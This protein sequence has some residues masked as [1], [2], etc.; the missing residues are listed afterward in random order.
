MRAQTVTGSETL[1]TATKPNSYNWLCQVSTYLCPLNT[2]CFLTEISLWLNELSIKIILKGRTHQFVHYYMPYLADVTYLVGTQ[3]QRNKVLHSPT[4][5]K[6][7]CCF[8]QLKFILDN[9][10]VGLIFFFNLIRTY[11]GWE[12]D[13]KGG[14]NKQM[15]K[16]IYV[17]KEY[18]GSGP[19]EDSAQQLQC[20]W[21]SVQCI[22]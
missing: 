2:G 14:Q 7:P 16:L 17:L 10:H 22:L 3:T 4:H 9:I 19:R 5:W 13:R 6:A 11:T 15:T 12:G 8:S 21:G 18:R 1:Q 20:C